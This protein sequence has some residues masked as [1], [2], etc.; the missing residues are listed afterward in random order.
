MKSE[1]LDVERLLQMKNQDEF[2]WDYISDSGDGQKAVYS[3]AFLC[4]SDLVAGKNL[5]G[6]DH[7]EFLTV[8]AEN[9]L[10][11][12]KTI[13]PRGAFLFVGGD[14]S[15]HISDYGTLASRFQN[16]FWWAFNDLHGRNSV[17]LMCLFV[18]GKPE[19]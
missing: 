12:D 9:N 16:P 14:T 4:M 8:D 15:Y 1:V 2:W 5:K 7:L 18:A 19:T 13:L 11:D 10:G 6:D 3:V 17:C